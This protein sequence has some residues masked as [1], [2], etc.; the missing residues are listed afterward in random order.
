MIDGKS[1]T[2]ISSQ[3][4]AHDLKIP[5]SLGFD[6]DGKHPFLKHLENKM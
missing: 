2:S 6:D 1:S 3:G 5:V 4:L